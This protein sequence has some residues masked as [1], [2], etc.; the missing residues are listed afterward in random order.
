VGDS[1]EGA[2]CKILGT[3]SPIPVIN[4]EGAGIASA[5]GHRF[6]RHVQQGDR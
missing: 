4:G 1:P 5:R 2:C 6:A 3:R